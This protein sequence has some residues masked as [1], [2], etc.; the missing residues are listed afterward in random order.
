MDKPVKFI[1]YNPD[2]KKYESDKK[3]EENLLCVLHKWSN[4]NSIEELNAH[5]ILYI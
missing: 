5:E 2:S 3:K 4:I 1:R